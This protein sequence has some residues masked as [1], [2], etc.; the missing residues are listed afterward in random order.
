M[1]LSQR[2]S[3]QCVPSDTAEIC[4]AEAPLEPRLRREE[5]FELVCQHMKRLTGGY[6]ADFDDLVQIAAERA[7]RDLDGFEGRSSLSTW[8]FRVCYRTLLNERRW[9][10]RWLRRF[11]FTQKGELPDRGGSLRAGA[12]E[13][14]EWRE[15]N[16]RLRRAVDQLSPKLR[17]VVS[18]HDFEELSVQQVSEL[19]N[20]NPLTVRSRLRDGR[21]ALARSLRSDG[22]FSDAACREGRPG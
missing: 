21:Q 14:L 13:A 4:P 11:E 3:V 16:L 1:K 19:L 6:G 17:V 8:T 22:Y 18:L 10:R 9:Y 5:V 15:R 12:A 2:L 7:L 20:L